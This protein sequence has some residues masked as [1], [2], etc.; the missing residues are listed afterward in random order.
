MAVRI[1]ACARVAGGRA[2]SGLR[3]SDV[4]GS[5]DRPGDPGLDEFREGVAVLRDGDAVVGYV[6]S[7][8]EPMWAS[9]RRQERVWLLV[10]W[11]DGRRERIQEDYEPWTSVSELRDGHFVWETATGEIDFAATWLDGEERAH[12]WAA[13]GIHEDVGSYMRQR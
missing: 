6:A 5:R 1:A 4:E 12:A 10:T 11:V 7:I 3:S 9:F 8:V 13:V 2:L